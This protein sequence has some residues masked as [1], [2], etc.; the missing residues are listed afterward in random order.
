LKQA[1]AEGSDDIFRVYSDEFD[2]T[3]FTPE[4]LKKAAPTLYGKGSY[5]DDKESYEAKKD[6]SSRIELRGVSRGSTVNVSGTAMR[7][8]LEAGDMK[9]FIANL[10]SA[11][12]D[13]GQEIYKKFK[14]E[15][16]KEKKTE[17]M[18]TATPLDSRNPS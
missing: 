13:K 5:E 7:N 14:S 15:E 12:Q 17:S 8:Y 1:A 3:K 16:R 6:V 2:I 11:V 4:K 10:P 18:R 9:N